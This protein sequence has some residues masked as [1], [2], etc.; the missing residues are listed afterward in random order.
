MRHFV[1]FRACNFGF[2]L[3]DPADSDKLVQG[4]II[5]LTGKALR[6]VRFKENTTYSDFEKTLNELAWRKWILAHIQ[7]KLAACRKLRKEDLQAYLERIE[8]LFH[9]I[10]D[11]ALKK[12]EYSNTEDVLK[13]LQTQVL[14]AFV[15]GLPDTYKIIFKSRNLKDLKEV[16]SLALE[17]GSFISIMQKN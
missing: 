3:I 10:V 13:L 2:K 1:F 17:G 7:I 9:D 16:L 12:M 4:L 14:T 5:K 6:A 11:A 15:D 8:K